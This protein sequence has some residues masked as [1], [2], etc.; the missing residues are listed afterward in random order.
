MRMLLLVARRAWRWL[1]SQP[2]MAIATVTAQ[3]RTS[4]ASAMTVKCMRRAGRLPAGARQAFGLCAGS[5][6]QGEAADQFG[7]RVSRQC[8]PASLGEGAGEFAGVPAAGGEVMLTSV[9]EG[10][11][12]LGVSGVGKS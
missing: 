3:P 2:P 4:T 12:G 6:G 10:A 8:C 9:A 7:A 11:G 5:V 1:T